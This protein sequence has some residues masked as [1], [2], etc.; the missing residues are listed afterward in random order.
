[1][2]AAT[3]VQQSFHV[4]CVRVYSI[5]ASALLLLAGK[6]F[7]LHVHRVGQCSERAE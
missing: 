2:C 5:Q 7:A 3:V 4:L 6:H 1:M